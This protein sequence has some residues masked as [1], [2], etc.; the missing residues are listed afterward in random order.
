MTNVY[1]E[2]AGNFTLHDN[3]LPNYE[4]HRACIHCLLSPRS[5]TTW[6]ASPFTPFAS[7]V[8]GVLDQISAT[9]YELAVTRY[10]GHRACLIRRPLTVSASPSIDGTVTGGGQYRA[11]QHEHRDGDGQCRLRVHQLDNRRHAPVST[12]TNYS[13]VLSGNTTI[14]ANF[15]SAPSVTI[16][17]LSGVSSGGGTTV[18]LKWAGGGAGS[19]PYS[20]RSSTNM[21]TASLIQPL[22]R[23]A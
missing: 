21:F 9:A 4:Q 19:T 1:F 7:S 2:T 18:T 22:W 16:S 15:V 13:F 8:T 6:T 10:S 11:G 23:R 5:Q 12:L 17:N 3:N 14:V 20:V